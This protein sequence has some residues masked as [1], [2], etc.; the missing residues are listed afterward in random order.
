[1]HV[2]VLVEARVKVEKV[3]TFK[4]VMRDEILPV[5]RKYDG[6]QTLVMTQNQDD[7]KHFVLVE[8][9]TSRG[10]YDRYLAWRK[11]RGDLDRI[12]PMLSE[13]PTFKFF[14]AVG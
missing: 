4:T 10:H 6:C 3:E 12:L 8:T 7:A 14:D 1:M 13:P 9:W 2:T 11:E 5:T